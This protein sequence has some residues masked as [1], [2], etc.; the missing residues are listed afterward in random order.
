MEA[1]RHKRNRER[2]RQTPKRKVE[3][4]R[5]KGIK[6]VKRGRQ[7]GTRGWGKET[8]NYFFL[9]VPL[10][11]LESSF[12]VI[13]SLFCRQ[14]LL[15]LISHAFCHVRRESHDWALLPWWEPSG[16]GGRNVLLVA[17]P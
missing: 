16:T 13:H 5:E 9:F 11:G 17:H 4:Q 1:Q 12:T 10:W 14:Q 3:R 8:G 15:W 6:K 2:N 7:S